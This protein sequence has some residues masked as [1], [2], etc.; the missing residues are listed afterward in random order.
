MV[1]QKEVFNMPSNTFSFRMPDEL[2]AELEKLSKED[3][4]SLSNLIIKV[5]REY[6]EN[7]CKSGVE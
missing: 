7:K 5:L 6:V 2:R 3:G 1:L 4:R